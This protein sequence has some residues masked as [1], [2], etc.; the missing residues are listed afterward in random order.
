MGFRK[1][2]RKRIG[3][4]GPSHRIC[5]STFQC[6]NWNRKTKTKRKIE[7]EKK[8][9][10]KTRKQPQKVR[11]F[12]FFH[13]IFFCRAMLGLICK[14]PGISPLEAIHFFLLC[15]SDVAVTHSPLISP[16]TTDVLEY[17]I[18]RKEYDHT[19]LMFGDLADDH[20]AETQT[21]K[22]RFRLWPPTL[23]LSPA[24][25][26]HCSPWQFPESSYT[27]LYRRM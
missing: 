25:S 10:V 3:S 9:S 11:L 16:I 18:H 27:L 22:I 17:T 24:P 1:K 19:L 15:H 6:M 26:P 12:F 7:S 8:K 20:I 14:F 21:T 13:S 4:T 5:P 2:C 23:F